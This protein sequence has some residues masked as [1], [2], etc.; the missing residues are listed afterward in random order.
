MR[1]YPRILVP[2]WKLA[3]AG[4]LS[5]ALVWVVFVAFQYQQT[6]KPLSELPAMPPPVVAAIPKVPPGYVQSM[7]LEAPARLTS[8]IGVAVSPRGDRIYATE[9]AGERATLVF[10]QAGTPIGKLVPPD[11]EPGGRLPL[12]VALDPQG[13]VYVSDRFR[14]AIDRYSPSGDYL[15][16]F[17]PRDHRPVDPLAV[18]FDKAGNFYVT[19]ALKGQHRLLVYDPSGNLKLMLGK[20]GQ[21]LGEFSFPNGVAVDGRGNIYVADS[22]NGRVQIFTPAGEPLDVIGRGGRGSLGSPRGLAIDD[23]GRLFVVD[24]MAHVVE[25]WDITDDPKRLHVAGSEGVGNGEFSYPNGLALDGSGRIYVTDRE[26][27]RVQVWSY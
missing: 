22:N 21:E 19:D 2:R 10:D 13:N 4:F 20:E 1:A 27:N 11:T 16:T 7:Y 17:E 24:T 12:Y 23:S 15:G 26:N 5:V 25:V 9:G 8:P 6:R 18:A 3:T 14:S